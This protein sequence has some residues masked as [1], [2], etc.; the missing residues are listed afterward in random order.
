MSIVLWKSIPKKKTKILL[1][2]NEDYNTSKKQGKCCKKSH[3][4]VY[5]AAEERNLSMGSS[6]YHSFVWV[7]W[8]KCRNS[9]G[10]LFTPAECRWNWAEPASSHAYRRA[11]RKKADRKRSVPLDMVCT[12]LQSLEFLGLTFGGR[13]IWWGDGLFR[14]CWIT[15]LL[16]IRRYV[17]WNALQESISCRKIF[18]LSETY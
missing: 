15:Y 5:N 18:S 16:K 10:T 2:A 17:A 4:I 11:D 13:Y 12:D 1:Y 6:L 14:A 7:E 9:A 8:T 3:V